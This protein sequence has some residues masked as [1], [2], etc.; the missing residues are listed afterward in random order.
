M[1]LGDEREEFD[2]AVERSGIVCA[3]P[4]RGGRERRST[5]THLSPASR[6]ESWGVQWA[7]ARLDLSTSSG[8]TAVAVGLD[9]VFLFACSSKIGSFQPSKVLLVQQQSLEYGMGNLLRMTAEREIDPNWQTTKL[10][11]ARFSTS[12]KSFPT[13]ALK[14]GWCKESTKWERRE[15]ERSTIEIG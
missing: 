2:H 12:N 13:I 9:L 11:S 15:M 14:I 8:S 1:K 4:D 6:S 3:Q 7:V 5:Y 10:T